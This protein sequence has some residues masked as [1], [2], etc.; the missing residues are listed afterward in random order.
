MKVPKS[1]TNMFVGLMSRWTIFGEALLNAE[2]ALQ[3]SLPRRII[4]ASSG[5]VE[6]M[7]LSSG[8]RSSMRMNISQPTEPFFLQ[9][10]WS[11]ML[12]T[13]GQLRKEVMSLI[14]VV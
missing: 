10:V 5:F 8:V 4:I 13:F 12:T 9:I 7:Y 3:I 1:D 14:S 2:R 6:D 11:S